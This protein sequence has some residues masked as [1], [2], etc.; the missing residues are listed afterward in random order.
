M[1]SVA[2]LIR[3][4]YDYRQPTPATI[5]PWPTQLSSPSSSRRSGPSSTGSVITFDPETL[6]AR[7][8][9]LEEG[10]ASPDSWKL[11]TEYSRVAKKLERFEALNSNVR[12]LDEA[13]HAGEDPNELAPIV[14]EVRSELDRLQEDALFT[15]E[16]DPGDAVVTIHAGTGGT[17][18]QDWTEMLLRMYLRW[19]ADRGFQTELL[20]ASPGEEAGLKSATFTVKGENAYGILKA[21]RGVHRLVRLSP[22]D[23]AHRRHTSFA[24]VIV[25]PLL[26]EDVEVELDEGDLRID[27]YRASGAG[28]QHVNKTDSAVRITHV[29]SGIVVQCQNERSQTSN[30]QT[31][32]RILRSR[33]AELEQEKREAEL[34]RERGEAQEIGFG[35]QIRSYVLQPY[36]LVKDHRTEHEAGNTQGVLDGDLDG[37]IHAYLLARA[38]GRVV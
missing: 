11:S 22:F 8:A 33:L 6:N 18:A 1:I 30:K 35:S 34:A 3:R 16:Y 13:L 37:F 10:M 23:Q 19:A 14:A 26:D 29:P 31:A 32:L 2:R 20:E 25:A 12:F 4:V 5:V 9:E 17:D 24:Q 38:A 27:T 15:G 36:Q 21:E 7:L 28:G